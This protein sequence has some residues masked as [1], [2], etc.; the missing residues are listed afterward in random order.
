M[1]SVKEG[2]LNKMSLLFDRHNRKL[3]GYFYR[4]TNN[5]EKS[6]DMVQMVFYRML[7][8][9]HAFRGEGKFIY[10][11]YSIAKN[12]WLDYL[13]KK[14]IIDYGNKETELLTYPNREKSG[15]ELLIATERKQLLKIAMQQ[16]TPEKREAIVLSK[17]QGLRY[18]EIAELANC[19]ESTI[20]SRVH[21]GLMDLKTILEKLEL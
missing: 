1:D 5:G 7:K 4:L 14:N 20:K 16:L 21:R 10:W 15:E 8:Y 17:Y 19:T 18:Q 13:K 3:F 12:I 6:E 2:D 11:M 9:R